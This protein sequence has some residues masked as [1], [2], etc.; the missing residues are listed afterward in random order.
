MLVGGAGL[1]PALAAEPSS[2]A[3]ARPAPPSSAPAADPAAAP[4]VAATSAAVDDGSYEE[5]AFIREPPRLPDSM[6]T[7]AA[8]RLS[9]A[10][11]IQLAVKSNL[12]IVLVKQRVAIAEQGEL[13]SFGVFEPRLSAAVSH[14]SSD[15]A[16]VIAQNQLALETTDDRWSLGLAQ[17][18][19]LGTELALEWS[20]DRADTRLGSVAQ[21]LL[22][23]SELGLR[24]TQP[25]LRGFA[26][27]WEVPNAEVL[28]AEVATARARQD[29]RAG[30]NA[31]V[32]DTEQTYWD[33]VQALQ[34][35]QVQRGSL[36]L[37]EEQ[38][39]LTR[40]QIEAGVLPPS[41]LINAEGTLAQRELGLVQAEGG[42]AQAADQLR[43]LLNLP[44]E[45]WAQPLLPL[46]VP[47]FDDL[48]VGYET[49]L[50]QAL[51]NRPE[52]AQ[53]KLDLQRAALDVR[54]ASSDRLPQLDASVSYGLVGQRGD[55]SGA[56]D[57]LVSADARAWSALLNFTWTPL[58]RAAGA[59]LESLRLSER[60]LRTLQ[61]QTLLDLRLELRTAIR[62]LETAD[63][64]VRAAARFRGLAARSL[65]AEQ[66]KFLNG[67][68]SNFF[69]AQ[70]QDD[71]ARARLAELSA[72]IQH[73]KA[74]TSLRGAM[75]V[76]LDHRHVKLDV[77]A[78]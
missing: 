75:G 54:V 76:L 36:Q 32:R 29:Y 48:Q 39:L 51:K 55:Y 66:R 73:R 4:T 12:G 72:L 10:D 8:R 60:A 19:R 62:G 9:L 11:A 61:D 45:A 50:D 1:S 26:F 15:S 28:R 35:Y 25:L 41:D 43:Y 37:A 71:L 16:P 14:Q 65:D 24:L 59:R 49:A 56:L 3:S 17:R 31:T 53:L 78:R 20:N 22:Y 21:P 23:R 27:R 52:L 5:P 68:S 6:D 13:Q 42:I 74:A 70:R 7:Q 63:R 46:D 77:R 58:N 67:T 33:L 2:P 44:R 18:T 47:Q 69:V 64:S 34:S 30:L 57:R 38:L 40:R